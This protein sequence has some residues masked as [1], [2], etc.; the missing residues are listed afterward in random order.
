MQVLNLGHNKLKHLA[1]EVLALPDL[2]VL[3]AS[4]NRIKDFLASKQQQQQLDAGAGADSSST[5][6]V[7]N[8]S[9][10]KLKEL[11]E[12]LGGWPLLGWSGRPWGLYRAV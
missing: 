9:F 11:P 3:D 7:L 4:H 10:N 2:A 5:V 6:A 8:L 1:R 12:D